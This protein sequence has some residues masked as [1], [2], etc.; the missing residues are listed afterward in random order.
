MLEV[1]KNLIELLGL[2][3]VKDKQDQAERMEQ[4]KRESPSLEELFKIQN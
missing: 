2:Q 1:T 3:S 4:L